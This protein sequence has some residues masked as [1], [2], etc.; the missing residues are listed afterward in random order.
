MLSSLVPLLVALCLLVGLHEPC[1]AQVSSRELRGVTDS[2]YA[3]LT[4]GDSAAL[5]R[6]LA[7]DLV[8]VV[9]ATGAEFSKSQLLELARQPQ[10]PPPRFVVE[11]VAVHGSGAAALVSFRRTD[12]RSV[13]GV[14]F[15]AHWRVLDVFT[16]RDGHW[17]LVHHMQTW[18][19]APVK[20]VSLDSLALQAFVG[21]YAAAPGIVDDV[22]W[23]NGHLVATLTGFPPGARLVPVSTTVFSPDGV[24]ALIAFERDSLGR[25]IGYVQGYPDGRVDR[26]PKLQ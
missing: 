11:S 21:R 17:Q 22:H 8:W 14:D 23:E 20:A 10:N 7:D 3:A 2:L 19:V 6:R 15:P 9:G 13:A 12:H 18:L 4:R 5:R 26:R 25:V 1:R 24:G 16:R